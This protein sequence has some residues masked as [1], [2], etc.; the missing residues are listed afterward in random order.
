MEKERL[1]DFIAT[2]M[3]D[4]GFKIKKNY[5]VAN[6]VIDIYGILDTT[7][8]NVGVV[9]ACK[10]YEEPWKIGLDVLKDMENAARAT[11][12]SKIIIFTTS[13]FTHGA[14]VYAQKRNMKLVDRKGLMKIAKNYASKRTIVTEPIIDEDDYD[15]V[16][17]KPASLNPRGSNN[18]HNPFSGRKSKLN[19]RNTRNDYQYNNTITSRPRNYLKTSSRSVQNNLPNLNGVLDFFTN[20]HMVYLVVLL[21][22]ASLVSYLFNIITLG[23]WTGLGKI[24]TSAIICFG[25][26]LLVDRNL[27][28]VLFNGFIIFFISIIISIVVLT[29]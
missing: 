22:I 10:N 20:H 15:Y 12:S 9:V 2:I 4:S 16:N 21:V 7:V 17:T 23:P 28:D 5:Q 24:V 18:S 8:G 6:Q 27:S 25:G 26:L 13:S 3:E 19:D 29:V 11:K 14:A 1:V